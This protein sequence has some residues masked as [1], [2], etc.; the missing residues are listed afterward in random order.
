M[1]PILCYILWNLNQKFCESC[2]TW[3]LGQ[4]SRY[5]AHRLM[6]QNAANDDNLDFHE[7]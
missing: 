4:S 5:G 7:I 6:E 3:H 1:C 2:T